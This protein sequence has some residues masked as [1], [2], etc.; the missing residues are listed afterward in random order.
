MTGRLSLRIMTRDGQ[1][2][3]AVGKSRPGWR[4]DKL[5]QQREA[6]GLTL[7]GAGEQLREVARASG[8]TVPAANF[9]TLWQ[10]EQ[11]E[12]YPGPH[13]RR[14]YCL[15]YRATEPELGFRSALPDEARKL[16][17]TESS[18]SHSGAHVLAVERALLQL[19]PGTEDTDGRGVQQRIL[20]AWKRRHTGGDPN[21]PTL[22]MVGGYAGS[23]KSEFARFISQLT[24]WPVLDKDPITR[25]LV[26]RL[27]VEMGSE[28]N[29]RHTDLYRE[30]VRPLEYQCLLETAYANVDCAISTV[31]SAPFITEATDPRWMRRL[32]NRCEAR[33]VTVAV[34]W[35]QCDLDTMHEYISFRSAARD[36]WKLQN[37]DTYA[38]GIDLELRPVVPHLVV[39]NRLGS[40]ISLTDQVRQVFGTVFQ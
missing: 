19:A 5:R 37:W 24:G 21:K 39:D 30:K 2:V 16:K 17:F 35:I 28:P 34:V 15:L 6:H 3:G 13:Y 22:M 8:L 18:E 33:G 40:A 32:I 7:E 25:P 14:A 36:S 4:P 26:E 10:H 12:V 9:Q 23:G 11:G 20:D 38:A 29:D 1:A 31:L 27:L